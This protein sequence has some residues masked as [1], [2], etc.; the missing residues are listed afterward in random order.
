M[1]NS[2]KI[3]V[4]TP[5]LGTRLGLL[6]EVVLSIRRNADGAQH[7]LSCP[8]SK[9]S[10]LK[11]RFPSARVVADQ[12]AEGGIYGAINNG[13]AAA[14][15]WDWFTY[16]NDDDLLLE[17]FPEL[18]RRHIVSQ[19]KA[20]IAYGNTWYINESGRRLSRF[21]VEK[22]PRYFRSLMRQQIAPLIQ[23]GMLVSRK[24]VD[25]LGG[26]KAQF[27]IC[28]DY[29]F[30]VRA[31][32]FGFG[33]RYYPLEVGAFRVLKGQVSGNLADRDRELDIICKQ[34][35]SERESLLR[36]LYSRWRF[37]LLNANVYGGRFWKIG[38][39]RSHSMLSRASSR[40]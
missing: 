39:R 7:I 25:S 36:V 6:S 35:S 33:F 15:S 31:L 32:S 2:S 34:L 18:C 23:Q 24:I 37:R 3:L 22:N 11:E 14:D 16:I 21:P 1:V 29:D 4:I 13:I 28:A 10:E 9:V 12:G 26:F 8:S 27:C 40:V 30:F 20:S 5:T 38:W 17:G 19:D